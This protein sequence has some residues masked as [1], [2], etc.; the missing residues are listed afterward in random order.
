M[1]TTIR[2]QILDE[3]AGI[4]PY[5]KLEQAHLDD[6]RAWVSTSTNIF[7]IARPDKPP[8]HLVAYFVLIDPDHRS[9][10]LG[11]LI[12]ANLWL[13][14]GGHVLLNEHPR[15]TVL[16]ECQEELGQPAVFLRGNDRPFFA[17]VTQTVGPTAG[18]TDVSLWYLVQGS[19]HDHINF[20]RR[21]FADVAW[22]TFEE[23]LQTHPAIF[24]KHM[25][26]FTRKLITY[27]G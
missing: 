22:F 12:K 19:I 7:R 13:P 8:K 16:R 15:Q 14:S 1:K 23:I 24:D 10:L 6:A 4:I 18:H 11:E 27:L 21:E 20:E 9:I 25:H 3:L 26:R 2:D 17:T 5:D